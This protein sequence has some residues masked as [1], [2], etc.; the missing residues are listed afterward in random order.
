MYPRSYLFVPGNRPE[1][2]NK[3]CVAGAD[4]VIIDLEDSVPAAEKNAARA[5]L[6]RWLSSGQAVSI[7]INAVD[8]PWFLDDLALCRLPGVIAVVLSKAEQVKD[9]ACIARAGAMAIF[10]L[11]ESACGLHRAQALAQAPLVQALM[12][13]TLDFQLDMGI[14]GDRE[15]LLYYRS[16][17]VLASRLAGIQPPVDGVSTAIDAMEQTHGDALYA[18]RLGFGGKL[19]IHPKQVATVNAAFKSNPQEIAWAKRVLAATAASGGGAV[20]MDGKMVDLPL[21]RKARSI[22]DEWAGWNTSRRMRAD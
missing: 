8:T 13:G 16:Q 5:S 14:D 6:A 20:A 18:R 7:R 17:L 2:F 19:C 21:I 1:R 10:P 12:F 11:I 15:E 4:V 3:A 22:L 9:L